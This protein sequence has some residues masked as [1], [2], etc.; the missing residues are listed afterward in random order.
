MIE[1]LALVFA[2]L[3][4]DTQRCEGGAGSRDGARDAQ[5]RVACFWEALAGL[6]GGLVTGRLDIGL[7]G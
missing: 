3:G 5:T 4:E 2:T 7:L 6:L 1:G